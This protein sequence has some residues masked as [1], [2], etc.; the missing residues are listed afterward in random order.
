[1]PPARHLAPK[2]GHSVQTDATNA[3]GRT[4]SPLRG[5]RPGLLVVPARSRSDCPSG[6][7]GHPRSGRCDEMAVMAVQNHAQGEIHYPGPD[8]AIAPLHGVSAGDAG[9]GLADSAGQHWDRPADHQGTDL[10]PGRVP[11]RRGAG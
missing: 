2:P 1:M 8:L 5:I 11:L 3:N 6:P 10:G 4:V 7:A 9:T